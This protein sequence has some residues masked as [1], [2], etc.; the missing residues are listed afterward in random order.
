MKWGQEWA[1]LT[2]G[3]LTGG[4]RSGQVHSRRSSV[5]LAGT[6]RSVCRLD[7]FHRWVTEA[8]MPT[9]SYSFRADGQGFP[10]S[11]GWRVKVGLPGP[12]AGPGTSEPPPR[13]CSWPAPH[14]CLLKGQTALPRAGPRRHLPLP[15]GSPPL[16]RPG[17]RGPGAA[18]SLTAEEEPAA[19]GQRHRA[20]RLALRTAELGSPRSQCLPG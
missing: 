4:E 13:G 17:S 1:S 5:L 20:P 19:P 15:G 16:L 9:Q 11:R 7:P 2:E 14:G 12:C 8:E 10:S 6:F 3:L 18:L